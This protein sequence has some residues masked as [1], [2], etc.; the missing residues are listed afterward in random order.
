MLF[1][2]TESTKRENYVYRFGENEVSVIAGDDA[3]TKVWIKTLHSLDDAEVYNNI[4]NSRPKLTK[5][6][7]A[8][9]REWEAKHPGENVPKNWNLS[10]DGL[11]QTEDADHSSYMKEAVDLQSENPD[12]LRE[13]LYAVL[14]TL[15]EE[16]MELYRMRYIWEL[17]QGEIAEEL[18]VSQNTVSKRLRKLEAKITELCRSEL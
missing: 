9:K 3:E 8:A 18:G 15:P 13:I 5:K 2:K 4:K 7:K 16:E 1:R 14:E 12:P 10:L 17:S 6:E 11:A